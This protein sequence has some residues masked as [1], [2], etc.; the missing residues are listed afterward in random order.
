MAVQN[1]NFLGKWSFDQ[2]N[3]TFRFYFRKD[4]I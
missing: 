2:D 3:A 1:R 4:V